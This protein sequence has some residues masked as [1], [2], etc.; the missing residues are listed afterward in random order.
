[1]RAHLPEEV[2]CV[3][4]YA[5]DL[6]IGILEDL[7]DALADDRLVFPHHH[8][9]RQIAHDITCLM[10]QKPGGLSPPRANVGFSDPMLLSVRDLPRPA[11]EGLFWYGN[12]TNFAPFKRT[13]GVAGAVPSPA[14]LRSAT[15][16]TD[17]APDCLSGTRH[18]ASRQARHPAGP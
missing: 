6:E 14:S 12:I 2:R 1:M 11:A 8:T 5:D 7:D 16:H 4:G 3:L 17:R 15:G 10:L 18:R 9:N 13:L